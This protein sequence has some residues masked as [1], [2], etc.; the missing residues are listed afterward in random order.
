MY[1]SESQHL[2]ILESF[3]KHPAQNTLTQKRALIKVIISDFGTFDI[4]E[5]SVHQVQ[6]RLMNDIFHSSSWKNMYLSLLSEI[7]DFTTFVCPRQIERPNFLSFV[8]NSKKCDVFYTEELNKL[9]L[10][11]NWETK[12]MYLFFLLTFNC[13]L[14]LGECRGLLVRQLFFEEKVLL[15]DGFCDRD[16]KR[17][18]HCKK[19]SEN[20]KKMRIAPLSEKL[21]KE[22]S[23]YIE[24]NNKKPGDFLFSTEGKAINAEHAR[25]VFYKALK[26]SGIKR[27]NRKLVPHS[28]RFTYVTRM[29]RLLDIES[30]RKIVGHATPEMTEYYTR[31]NL[32]DLIDGLNKE[33]FQALEQ[34]FN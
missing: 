6:L 23:E 21:I 24:E 8:R 7:Y 4:R 22:L 33:T 32:Q 18:N 17:I 28:L 34:L 14:R 27:E 16:G 29:R 9:F 11:E 5:L 30:T 31:S 19:G 2:K 25:R 26:K 15:V 10:P 20:N 1:L 3:G 12:D 13:G